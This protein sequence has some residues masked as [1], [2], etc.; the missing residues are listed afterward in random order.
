MGALAD[1][2]PALQ[3]RLNREFLSRGGSPGQTATA[4]R[5]LALSWAARG[6]WDSVTAAL[7]RPMPLTRENEY[8]I[9]DY[10][11]A[12]AG[13]VFG[14]VPVHVA[15]DLRETTPTT[16]LDDD[17]RARLQWLDGVLAFVGGDPDEVRAARAALD[18]VEDAFLQGLGPSLEGLAAAAEGDL[19]TAAETLAAL[20]EGEA[21]AGRS[22]ALLV[23]NPPQLPIHRL[24]LARWLRELGD[25]E[26]AIRMLTWTDAFPVGLSSQVHLVALGAFSLRERAE[27]AEALGQTARARR[28]YGRFLALH[29]APGPTMEPSVERARAALERLPPG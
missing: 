28:L 23:R 16:G 22:A 11:V 24:L 4:Q 26:R 15:R 14:V 25:P 20:E 18:P 13:A 10:G 21:E 8:R 3:V 9:D 5:G 19:R 1:F 27:L 17:E 29:D 7:G 12:V 6:A 2:H